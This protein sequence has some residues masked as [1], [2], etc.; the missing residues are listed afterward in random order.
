VKTENRPPEVD[1]ILNATGGGFEIFARI[2]PDFRADRRGN[3][4]NPTY[5]DGNPSLSVYEGRGGRWRW[6]DFGNDE[7]GDALDLFAKLRGISD[8]IELRRA[9]AAEF[10]GGAESQRQ[11]A[12]PIPKPKPKPRQT[13]FVDPGDF[14]ARPDTS[15]LADYM[16][17]LFGPQGREALALYGVK[18]GD[19]Y[20][21]A[22]FP[23]ADEM[24]RIHGVKFTRYRMDGARITKKNAN[25]RPL[26][27]RYEPK[28]FERV[29]FGRHLIPKNSKRRT[30]GIVEA[31]DTALIAAAC[32]YFPGVTFMASGGQ[33]SP[34]LLR[35]LAG[36]RLIYYPDADAT[37]TAQEIAR[38]CAGAGVRVEVVQPLAIFGPERLAEITPN[39]AKCDLKD[40]ITGLIARS[41]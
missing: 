3:Y 30:V 9:L 41:R 25:G 4:F 24:G 12:R 40:V 14:F 33:P 39:P 17:A 34:G 11:G 26:G 7:G 16:S 8:F 15:T 35:G 23:I 37:E 28:G 29:L 31:E 13:E 21:A 10:M 18:R 19:D 6:K 2:I 36:H 27:I 1:E 22:A 32:G 5:E 38:R 20:S